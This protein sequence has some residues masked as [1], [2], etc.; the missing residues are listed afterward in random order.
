ML[1]LLDGRAQMTP[2][3]IRRPR[4]GASPSATAE[5]VAAI[6][7]DVRT[8]GDEAI[9]DHG[10]RTDR[11]P[12]SASSLRVPEEVIGRAT[13]LV[14]PEL[15]A[16]LE[17]MAERLRRTCERQ[18]DESW[19]ERGVD[20]LVGELVRPLR[21]VGVHV[22]AGRD[23][24]PSSI[25]MSV[26]PAQ[27][28]GVEGIAVAS[29]PGDD[30]EVAEP[31]LA[32]CAVLGLTEVYRMWGAGAIAALAF[33]TETVRPVEKIVGPGDVHVRSA[34]R[35]V[36]GWV[37][38]DADGGA[39]EL[40]IIADGHASPRILAA[41]LIA[42]AEHGPGGAHVLITWEPALVEQV[43]SAMDMQVA[44]HER[45]DDVENALIEGGVAVLVKD[46]DHA[47]D[48]ANAFAPEHLHL[49]FENA[50]ETLDRVRNAGS[51]AVGPFSAVPAG[52]YVGGTNH[53]LPSGGSARWS[54]G[55]S[56]RAF[57][58]RIY[59]SGLEA[60]ALERLAPHVDAL[61]EAEG[62]HGHART[63]QLRLEPRRGR[64]PG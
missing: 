50:I 20:D 41:D 35:L 46:L 28:A 17:V 4:P 32:A 8:R 47:L 48:T 36:R 22:P 13:S 26:V 21:R 49:Q 58:K 54:S 11:G 3:H 2:V 43:I 30:G 37:G 40:A 42:Q 56:V 44:T 25:V 53:V 24:H 34:K 9:L 33:G 45:S 16:A 64:E 19:M 12:A 38:T 6:V 1:E 15:V 18:L 60:S 51:V 29:A 63:V 39:A 61:A 57:V 27:V 62:L 52:D 23:A 5:D 31:V 7:E 55:L 10:D 14:R 59:V